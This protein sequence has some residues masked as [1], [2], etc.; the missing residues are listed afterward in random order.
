M[1]DDEEQIPDWRVRLLLR[2]GIPTSALVVIGISFYR[3][4][5]WT[6]QNVITPIVQRQVQVLTNM[7]DLLKSA[8]KYARENQA[9]IRQQG[10]TL[11]Q[12]VRRLELLEKESTK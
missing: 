1:S 10:E 8:E 3:A 6:G 7:E 12:L 5:T 9:L 2:L 11:Q 4:A